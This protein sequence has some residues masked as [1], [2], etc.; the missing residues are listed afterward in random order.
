MLAKMTVVE[1][2]RRQQHVTLILFLST[3]PIHNAVSILLVHLIDPQG[4][5][6]RHC[7]IMALK[8]KSVPA[9]FGFHLTKD[10]GELTKTKGV[11]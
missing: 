10:I 11:R 8:I 6:F 4:N 2:W 5:F 3:L 7:L 1:T 9:L